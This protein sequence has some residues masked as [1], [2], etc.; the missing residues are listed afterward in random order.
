M[1]ATNLLLSLLLFVFCISQLAP[2]QQEALG[3]ITG[4]VTDSSGAVVPGVQ[5][6][7][8]DVA[9]NLE[10]TTVTKSGGNYSFLDLPL[11]TYSVSFS[12]QGFQPINYSQE[13]VQANRTTTVSPVLKIGSVSAEVT[14]TESNA[15]NQV[16]T[17]N[18]YVLGDQVIQNTPLGTGSFTQLAI[19]SPGV[20]ADL[21][22]GSGTNAGLG[23]QA[24]WANGQRD[25][26]NSFAV[27]GISSNNLFNGKSTSQ[28]G[29]NRF[30]LNT[31]ERFESDGSIGT[32][33]SV[34]DAIG[35]A[36]PSPPVETLDELRVNTSMYD[37]SQG[38]NSGAHIELL[39][40]S[41]S[42]AWHGQTYEYFQNSFWNA[43]PFF[44]KQ[45]ILL[46][47]LPPGSDAVPALHRNTFGGTIG[48]PIKRDKLFFF[49]SYQGV[50]ASDQQDATSSDAVP[51][52]TSCQPTKGGPVISTPGLVDS[53]RNDPA[54]LANMINVIS[55]C[56]GSN[57]SFTPITAAQ[58]NP[59]ALA[60]LNIKLP[61]GSFLI[62]SVTGPLV[63]GADVILQGPS[64]TFVADQVNG[65]IDYNVND[66]DR[67]SSKYYF[68]RDP[69]ET[70]FGGG[71]D[72]NT[73]TL[74]FP[75][76]LTAGSHAYSLSNALN[77]GNNAVW[78]QRFGFTR[79]VVIAETGQPFGP[80][81]VGINL[82]SP[83]FPGIDIRDADGSFDGFNI[84]TT[85]N[86]ANAGMFENQ[87]E[88]GS[89]YTW[90]HGNHTFT[91]GANWDH[92][93]ENVEN[94]AP[95]VA[96]LSFFNFADFLT[97]NLRL[98]TGHT[99]LFSGNSNRHYRANQTG[100]YAQ[101]K[102]KL[103]NNLNLTLGLRY[104][105]DGPLTEANGLITNFD[106]SL[107]KYD[108]ATDTIVN[109]GLVFAGNNKQ[110]HTPGTS[111][112]T[113]T[114]RQ[115]GFA[116]RIGV[117]WSP[118]F[119]KN[120]V[121][122]SGFG[123]YYDRGEFFSEFSPS[124]GFGF[125]GPFGVTLEPPFIVPVLADS[126]STFANP[127]GAVTPPP[128]NLASVTSLIPNQAALI[129]TPTS[130]GGA[131]PFLFGGYDPANKLPYS[132]NWTL[133][134]Q[135]QPTNT[136]VLTMGY[137]GN[138][139]VHETVPIP[140][141]QPQI[142]TPTHPVNGQ[143]Y[144][145]GYTPTDAAGGALPAESLFCPANCMPF[146]T[147]TGGNTDLRVP[148]IGYNPN[149]VFWEAAGIS[150]YNALQVGAN[151]R[152]GHGLQLTASYTWS[153]T[154]DE[155]SGLGLFFNGNNPLDLHSAYASSDFD[156]THVL[157]LSYLYELPKFSRE[158][159]LASKFT[160]GWGFSGV[161]VAE[162]GQPYN[163]YDFSGTLGGIYY[164]ANDFI[165]N[166]ILG[167]AP[168]ISPGQATLNGST[169][170][171]QPQVNPVDFTIPLLAPGQDGVPP[172][173]TTTTGTTN[174]CD[175]VET[176]FSNGGRNIFRGPFQ[177]RFDM[178]LIKN[179]KISERFSLKYTFDAFNVF[180][181]PSFDTPNNNMTLNPCFNPTPCYQTPTA[182]LALPGS[183]GGQ[184]FGVIQHTIGSPRFLQ[185]SLHLIY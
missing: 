98:G 177:T 167:L 8:H 30:V 43:A 106:P 155:Q 172:C 156:R 128:N 83:V 122:R 148:F 130:F 174:F 108:L 150:N 104:D 77:A 33:T 176:P 144:S 63:N 65:N 41:G 136:L 34:Y 152:M 36:V 151:K 182:S 21:L 31:G 87:Y 171:N 101:D 32:A 29:D 26:S 50:R 145:F 183:L 99:E 25:T 89:N 7:I 51:P 100:A 117:A 154:L 115:W 112:S 92:I 11:G 66:K 107:Y 58:I 120:V 59:V 18:G 113:L 138:H 13:F 153:H 67:L 103:T 91:F 48:G 97:G 126:S 168:G 35:E 129:G 1:K 46:G 160:N 96:G 90:V 75:Q 119:L 178:S 76:H 133:D 157:T 84:G 52:A 175:T 2:A 134:L 69:T 16:D 139:G 27:N 170:L 86:F 6:K 47:N 146:N 79:E 164:S 166:P 42:N 23:N 49:A 165:T 45:N 169:A 20:N 109:D 121:V 127:F 162:S 141:N 22:G 14:V 38:A 54:G 40:K 85:S 62:P 149:S 184:S 102:I 181:H 53:L 161:T 57:T 118:S 37:A 159:S 111:D 137:V 173:G 88:L 19:L 80:S 158:D 135:W 163:I 147:S 44:R 78:D 140:F 28:V 39:T 132:E 71:G 82:P 94:R 64:A 95:Q 15:L 24:I 180:N 3:S 60:L 68:Q 81:A 4:T 114:G 143:I 110:F 105:Y 93:Q 12:K 5:V 72:S 125:N 73:N 131:T 179:T 9:T 17:T 116:P 74:G 124:A 70:P 55:Q 185:M 10:Q 61:N 142:A 56:G 123:I